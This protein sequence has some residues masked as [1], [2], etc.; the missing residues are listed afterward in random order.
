MNE[1]SSTEILTLENAVS[2]AP[3]FIV[4]DKRTSDPNKTTL[5]YPQV[6]GPDPSDK[7]GNADGP[8]YMI[9]FVDL[10]AVTATHIKIWGLDNDDLNAAIYPVIYLVSNPKVY[11]WL[12]K[13]EFTDVNGDTEAAGGVYTIFGHRKRKHP[14]QF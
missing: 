9:E 1:L 13:F 11:V 10:N 12:D 6:G 7:I 8:I 5:K 4:T 3:V 2:Y 14:I